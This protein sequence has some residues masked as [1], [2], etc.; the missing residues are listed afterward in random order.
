MLLGYF[1]IKDGMETRFILK[2]QS[3][4]TVDYNKKSLHLSAIMHSL[5]HPQFRISNSSSIPSFES[6]PLSDLCFHLNRE[7]SERSYNRDNYNMISITK[8]DCFQPI[9]QQE[10]TFP[11]FN[12]SKANLALQLRFRKRPHS[13][14]EKI[15]LKEPC[16]SLNTS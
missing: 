9:D 8:L 7:R 13:E 16:V 1:R 14:S 4:V 6:L 2:Y 12:K 11:S 15:M 3:R 10:D 5:C